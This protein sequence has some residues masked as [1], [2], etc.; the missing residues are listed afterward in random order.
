[1]A[2]WRFN[3]STL[4]AYAV[5]LVSAYSLDE[6]SDGSNPITRV[7]NIGS[8][9][10]TDN[11]NVVS[12][13]GKNNN[14]GDF[15]GSNSLRN[16][17][18]A[19]WV[20]A[21]NPYT[22]SCWMRFDGNPPTDWS[23]IW[24]IDDASGTPYFLGLKLEKFGIIRHISYDGSDH[25]VSSTA[26]L[27]TATYYHV[28]CIYDGSKLRLYINAVQQGT[29]TTYANN[30]GNATK[31]VLG[32]TYY[33]RFS[34]T[35]YYDGKID[36]IVYWNTDISEPAITA[37]YNVGD[38]RFLT[39][40]ICYSRELILDQRFS[41]RN[42]SESVLD[43]SYSYN[44]QYAREMIL[45]QTH[46]IRSC[47]ETE[48]SQGFHI[49]AQQTAE[50]KQQFSIRV[51]RELVLDQKYTIRSKAETVL[52]QGHD[53]WTRSGYRIVAYDVDTETETELGWI[54]AGGNLTL[55]FA[56]LE[57]GTYEIR[58]YLSG[59]IW[60]DWRLALTYYIKMES[61]GSPGEATVTEIAPPV[62]KWLDIEQIYGRTIIGWEYLGELGVL[63]PDQFYIWISDTSPV[64]TSGDPTAKEI[65]F[66]TGTYTYELTHTA[67]QYVALSAVQKDDIGTAITQTIPWPWTTVESPP[68]QF[69]HDED[70][71]LLTGDL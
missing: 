56:T 52:D 63:P 29:G 62:L 61:T 8:N 21:G 2:T 23:M 14:A 45:D 4:D 53:I 51:L 5:N 54:A 36:E 59:Y 64:D 68:V 67:I 70:L 15:S 34:G 44:K 6:D 55:E 32:Q 28:V 47:S 71:G 50:L 57:E 30:Y 19:G 48:L 22:V 25:Y 46:D 41:I 9:D 26:A 60:Q 69:A 17:S 37:L 39:E 38:G 12:I 13:A 58:V 24:A 16:L 31:F 43:Q 10:L 66:G 18:F 7:D 1:M 40:V 49:R 3:N 27:T 20:A 33:S 42:R 11:N 65:S 35:K